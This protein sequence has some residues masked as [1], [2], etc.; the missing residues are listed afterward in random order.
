[1]GRHSRINDCSLLDPLTL[2][3]GAR[4]GHTDFVVS[5]GRADP[6]SILNGVWVLNAPKMD[7]KHQK[8][9]SA[10]GLNIYVF[11]LSFNNFAILS[12]LHV[13]NT[14]NL[15]WKGLSIMGNNHVHVVLTQWWHDSYFQGT[16]ATELLEIYEVFKG[17][18]HDGAPEVS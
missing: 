2:R 8:A 12:S 13:L 5:G 17:L 4:L 16:M 14:E 9:A 15:Q 6:S 7:W 3:A 1:M 10:V 18:N 11:T